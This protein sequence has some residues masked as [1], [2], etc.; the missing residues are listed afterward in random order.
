MKRKV[1]VK[2]ILLMAVFQKGLKQET[3]TFAISGKNGNSVILR[4]EHSG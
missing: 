3:E 2:M 4:F 1:N